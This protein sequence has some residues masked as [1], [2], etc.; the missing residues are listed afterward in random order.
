M[1]ILIVNLMQIGDLVLTTPVFRAIKAAHPHSYLAAAVNQQFADLVKFNP[2]INR[3]F[4]VDKRSLLSFA[5]VIQAIRA[6]HFDLCINLNSSERACALAITSG[7]KRVV[8]YAKPPFSLLFSK[9]CPNLK[10]SIH[11]IKSHFNVLSVAGLGTL[12]LAPSDVFIGDTHLNFSLPDNIVALNV[13]ASWHSKRWLP[14]YFASVAIQLLNRGFH[15]AFLGSKADIPIVDQCLAL[16][17]DKRRVLVFTGKLSL[18]ELA[19]FFDRCRLLI[20]ND[21]GPMHIAAA[22]GLPAVS[23]FGSSPVTG[24]APWSTNHF[25]IKS[26]AKCHPCNKHHCPQKGENFM[27][28]MKLISPHIVLDYALLLL[29][30]CIPSSNWN[31]SCKIIELS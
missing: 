31:Y 21:S 2:F 25:I 30:S 26:P 17:P 5:K 24:F 13:G 10:R 15:V 1:K 12:P 3:L 19:A 20:S 7:A 9:V 28:C 29:Q 23:I 8:G 27:K 18:L 14:E 4:L 11:Q 6:E 22:R 16:I